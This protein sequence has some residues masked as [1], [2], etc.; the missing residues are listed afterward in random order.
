MLEQPPDTGRLYV[1]LCD[2]GCAVSLRLFRDRGGERCAIGFTS[3]ERL[4]ALL[5]PHQRYYRLLE[6]SVRALARERGVTALVVDPRLVAAAVG[7]PVHATPDPSPDSS[8]A[9]LPTAATPAPVRAEQPSRRVEALRTAWSGQSAGILAV[10]A[11]TGAAAV[12]MEV[13]K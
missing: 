11:L 1:P 8:P 6:R 13:L 12:A 4:I 5:G 7:E 9:P 10:S 2:A 3:E